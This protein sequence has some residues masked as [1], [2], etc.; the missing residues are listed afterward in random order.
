MRTNNA[1]FI[2]NN[3][4][5]FPARINESVSISACPNEGGAWALTI[6]SNR[7]NL[8]LF[9]L[10]FSQKA[11]VLRRYDGGRLV[12]YRVIKTI[13]PLKYH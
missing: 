7:K 5:I 12:A 11:V 6:D 4:H 3:P 2:I 13:L 1:G 10:C 8:V 9:V